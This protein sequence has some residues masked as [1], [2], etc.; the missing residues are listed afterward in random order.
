MAE[1]VR[2]KMMQVPADA[3]FKAIT[4]FE[5]YPQF[6]KEVTGAKIVKQPATNKAW[7]QF[8]IEVV[9]KFVYILE[10]TFKGK[11]EIHWK[12]IESDFFKKNEGKWV[13][14]ETNKQQTQVHYELDVAVVF[15]VPSWIAKKL[16]EV[17]LPKM[18]E[19]FE[20]RAKEISHS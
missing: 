10:F 11:E 9:K 13:L 15:M 19:G 3:L 12:L 17:N 18:F 8:E 4:E 16:T 7:V 14:T 1:V 5:K 6:L 2:D 20:A